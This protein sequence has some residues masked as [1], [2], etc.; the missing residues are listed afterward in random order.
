MNAKHI[1]VE[2]C[3]RRLE[4]SVV[5]DGYDRSVR[6]DVDDERGKY[7]VVYTRIVLTH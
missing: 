3:I 4:L 1:R 7:G 5:D 2:F 6:H